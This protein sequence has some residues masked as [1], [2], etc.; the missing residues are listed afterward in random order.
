[1]TT[2][3][4]ERERFIEERPRYERLSEVID[5]ILHDEARKL[6]LECLFQ[7]R[8]KDVS[9]LVKKLLANPALSYEQVGDKS[10]CR[11]IVPFYNQVEAVEKTILNRFVIL[12][13]ENK[14]AALSYDKL[15]Y[16]GVHL[17]VALRADDQSDPSLDGLLCEI[18]VATSVQRA[19]A[20]VSHG[21]LYKP[22]GGE[23]LLPEDY[24]RS[25]QR[26]VALVEIFDEET[27]RALTV[28]SQHPQFRET[29]A[30]SAFERNF[31]RLTARA[32]NR[33][34]S[35]LTLGAV[36]RAYPA[37]SDP[38]SLVQ[39]FVVKNEAKL[40]TLFAQY[41]DDDRAN[42]FLFQPEALAIF[43]R[44][45]HDPFTLQQEWI[46]ILPHELLEGLAATWGLSL[47][48]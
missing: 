21:L 7:N 17:E 24:R 26:L 4:E 8:A 43:E 29:Q 13:H 20:D 16:L 37:G 5:R 14:K 18:Q 39:A 40:Q 38:D 36:L 10:G 35:L 9:S 32:Y 2:R 41:Q 27:V 23:Q 45:E 30:L 19:W 46:E 15:G 42:P 33:E 28:A 34:L 3:E 31:Y 25:V 22:K 44:L 1:L 11:V 47:P 48:E 6:G 12:S